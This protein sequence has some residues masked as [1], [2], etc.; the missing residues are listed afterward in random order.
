[1]F[2]GRVV[3]VRGLTTRWIFHEDRGDH[4]ILKGPVKKGDKIGGVF[5]F[6]ERERV[7]PDAEQESED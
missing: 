1:M 5:K 4:I 6:V 3:R 2:I 7:E